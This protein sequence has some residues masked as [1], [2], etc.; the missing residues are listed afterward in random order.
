MTP[1][2]TLTPTVGLVGGLT[3][4]FAE[5]PLSDTIGE[6]VAMSEEGFDLIEP[7]LRE[8]C[9]AWT[10][11]HRYGV[12]KL[13]LSARDS[14]VSSLRSGA[15]LARND[16][17]DRWGESELLDSVA[18]WLAGRRHNTEIRILGI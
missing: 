18:N 12:F 1:D 13:P 15:V 2:L 14:L 10:D 3:I 4:Q 8:A 17:V 5:C 6:G 11:M 7:Y 9:P 16:S